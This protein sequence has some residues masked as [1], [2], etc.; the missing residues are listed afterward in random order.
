MK[1]VIIPLILAL[2]IAYTGFWYFKA[3]EAKTLVAKHLKESE[4]QSNIAYDDLKIAGFPF[5]YKIEIPNLKVTPQNDSQI[6]QIENHGNVTV[7]TNLNGSSYWVERSGDMHLTFKNNDT[8]V[9]K[10]NSSIEFEVF[11]SDQWKSINHPFEDLPS[12]FSKNTIFIPSITILADQLGNLTQDKIEGLKNIKGAKISGD[13]LVISY[14]SP[15]N[16]K[17]AEINDYNLALNRSPTE[18]HVEYATSLNLKDYQTFPALDKYLNLVGNI[19]TPLFNKVTSFSSPK[20]NLTFEAE[21]KLPKD[22]QVFSLLQLPELNIN[23]KKLSF[24]NPESNFKGNALVSITD[25]GENE[26]RIHFDIYK[27]IS[28]SKAGY[29]NYKKQT[30]EAIETIAKK[31]PQSPEGQKWLLLLQCCK[32]DIEKVIPHYD[33]LSPI[34]FKINLDLDVDRNKNSYNLNVSNLDFTTKEFG[35]TSGG[36]MELAN[37]E[38]NG[39]YAFELTNYKTLIQNTIDY[40]NSLIPLFMAV[41]NNQPDE[42]VSPVSKKTIDNI[43]S[44]LQRISDQP[45]SNSNN[46][47]ITINFPN[48]Q[49]VTVGKLDLQSFIAEWDKLMNSLED[50]GQ[51][52]NTDL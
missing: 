2:L 17:I 18:N 47:S 22:L 3:S 14:D 36:K 41:E 43:N 6:R 35:V 32:D 4:N 45:E 10:G 5:S 31:D 40:Y 52:K 34:V 48:S 44:F 16:E 23:V 9:E 12:F 25:K 24:D 38:P 11:N 27:N 28:V 37:M 42:K 39:K 26:K 49:Q 8:I 33:Q 13:H 7:A 21:A 15:T 30:L 19:E 46:I 1:K 51:T 50:D 29:E 20:N